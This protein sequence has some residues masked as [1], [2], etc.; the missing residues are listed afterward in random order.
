MAHDINFVP[1]LTSV[2]LLL[3]EL[4]RNSTWT[5]VKEESGLNYLE[6]L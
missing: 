4:P 3:H 2:I 1:T 5:G 6:E